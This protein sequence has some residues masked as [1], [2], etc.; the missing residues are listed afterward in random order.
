MAISIPILSDFNSKGIDSAIREFKKLETAGQKAQFAIKKAAVPAALALAGLAT[1]AVDAVKAFMEDDKAAQL[2]A[3]SLRNTTGATDA[4]IKSVEAFITKT[5]I[6]AA[7]AD[8]ELRPALD[9]LVRGTGDVTK[10]QDL[11]N[12]ALNISAG[13]GKDLGAVSDALSKAFNG[14]LGPLKKLDPALAGLIENG[15]TTDEVFAALANTFK[16]AAS[17]SANTAS[18]KMKSFSIQMGEFKESVGAAVFPIV[19]KLLPAFKS[20]A[21]FIQNNTGLVVGF[22]VVFAGL[23]TTIL[24]VNAAMKAYAAIQAI[25][26]VATNIL[27]AST[28]ALWIATGVA[29]IVAIIAALVALQAKFDIFGK[30]VDLVKGYFTELWNVARFVFGAIKT[31]FEGLKDIGGAIFDNVGGAF[32]DVINKVIRSLESGLNFAISGLNKALDGIDAAA[33]PLVNF[34][35]IPK[36]DIPELAQG[37]IVTSPTIAMI[38]EAGPEAVIPLNRAG[39]MGMGGNT[40]TVNVNGGDPNSV[41][42]ALQQYVRQSGPVPVNTRAM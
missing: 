4:Q 31:G 41:V 28:Y 22:G 37:G 11:L 34:G 24:A 1:V 10:A 25:V 17:T 18:G 14:Q 15:A 16:G 27:T 19:D 33:G 5:S 13:T 3:T 8:D 30:T 2:L 6:A 40:I 42:R 39:G 29:V 32:K 36:V 38:G 7:V 20:V 9:K 21:D 12:L 35:S 23:A 26:T